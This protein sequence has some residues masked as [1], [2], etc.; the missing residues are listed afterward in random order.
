MFSIRFVL[1]KWTPYVHNQNILLKGSARWQECSS[2][3]RSVLGVTVAVYVTEEPLPISPFPFTYR[4]LLASSITFCTLQ[5]EESRIF[6]CIG[7]V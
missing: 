5:Y 2:H 4:T 1:I 6:Q 7:E 3:P